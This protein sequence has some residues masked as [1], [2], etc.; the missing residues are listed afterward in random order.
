MTEEGEACIIDQ[1]DTP[2]LLKSTDHTFYLCLSMCV[3]CFESDG[4]F[5]HTYSLSTFALWIK[6]CDTD[7]IAS[8]IL[9]H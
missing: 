5:T 4:E 9:R 2:N 7:M 3:F 1:N 6:G 8:G